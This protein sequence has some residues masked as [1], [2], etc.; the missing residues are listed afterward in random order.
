MIINNSLVL[1]CKDFCILPNCYIFSFEISSYPEDY[2]F[3][4]FI[5]NISQKN[6]LFWSVLLSVSYCLF[7]HWIFLFF[8]WFWCLQRVSV[9]RGLVLKL[10]VLEDALTHL[11]NETAGRSLV[12]GDRTGIIREF[13][14]DSSYLNKMVIR[15]T[16]PASVS[17]LPALSYILLASVYNLI[18][19]D[20]IWH[21]RG[22]PQQ[23]TTSVLCGI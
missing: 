22:C 15:E 14:W 17:L 4:Q 1:F 10:S 2:I 7:V 20:R 16:S 23:K 6:N 13:S 5:I 19:F 21:T 11:I 12:T 8:P 9:L 3:G 18:V